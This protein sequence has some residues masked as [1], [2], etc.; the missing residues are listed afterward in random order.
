[1]EANLGRSPALWAFWAAAAV[2]CALL[3]LYCGAG[4]GPDWMFIWLYVGLMVMAAVACLRRA[5]TVRAERAAWMAWAPGCSRG[6]PAR[7]AG[8]R[9]YNYDAVPVPS[10]AD[11]AISFYPAAF[12]PGLLFRVRVRAFRSTTGSTGPSRPWRG[13]A[14]S[15]MPSARVE[16]ATGDA[17]AMA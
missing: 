2:G 7:S 10:A 9:D 17:V 14:A 11:A 8:P 15:A 16:A 5:A 6:P 13:V 3:L 4:V 12:G 1:M